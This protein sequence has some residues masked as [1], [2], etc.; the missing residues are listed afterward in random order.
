MEMVT[1]RLQLEMRP[2]RRA[3]MLRW[4]LELVRSV[5]LIMR[6]PLVIFRWWVR[7]LLV[8]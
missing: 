1:V 2:W 8:L 7:G 4:L 6:R 5:W 3:M